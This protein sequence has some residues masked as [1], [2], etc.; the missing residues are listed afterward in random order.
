MSTLRE[1]WFECHFASAQGEWVRFLRGWN[2]A[3]AEAEFREELRSLLR[4]EHG[5]IRVLRPGARD[6]RAAAA[7]RR[8][9]ARPRRA[10]RPRRQRH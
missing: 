2:A 7:R 9:R 6:A 1:S 3:A 10:A 8:H 5:T 4:D